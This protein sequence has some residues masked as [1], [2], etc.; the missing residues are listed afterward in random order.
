MTVKL[1]TEHR[2]EFLSLKIVIR[3]DGTSPLLKVNDMQLENANLVD[4]F[5]KII[6][7]PQANIA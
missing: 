7:A 4:I 1:L 5:D 6:L 3:R 2:L